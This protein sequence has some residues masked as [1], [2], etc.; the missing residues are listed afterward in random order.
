MQLNNITA[1]TGRERGTGQISDETIVRTS[2]NVLPNSNTIGDVND[3]SL[4]SNT[5]SRLQ[6]W[7]NASS[8]N[9]SFPR[10]M[11][12]RRLNLHGGISP[13]AILPPSISQDSAVNVDDLFSQYNS[14]AS[15]MVG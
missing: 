3:P 12:S 6:Q 1:N 15:S 4:I 10:N 7:R 5:S 9:N 14:I 2:T 11:R 8:L 13:G